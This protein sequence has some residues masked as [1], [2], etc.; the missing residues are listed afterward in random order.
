MAPKWRE[1][2]S[3]AVKHFDSL[4]RDKFKL[5]VQAKAQE[6]NCKENRV[7][8]MIGKYRIY[9]KSGKIDE[10]RDA[11]LRGQRPNKTWDIERYNVVI[12]IIKN[13]DALRKKERDAHIKKVAAER[14]VTVDSIIKDLRL[15]RKFRNPYIRK[16]KLLLRSIQKKRMEE[17]E[18][19]RKEIKY[20]AVAI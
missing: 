6:F 12:Y 8:R 11:F 1:V 10:E 4:N 18:E 7:R 15:Y 3:Y 13:F 2:A 17:L 20:E 9:L 5:Y 19:R 16:E 14:G